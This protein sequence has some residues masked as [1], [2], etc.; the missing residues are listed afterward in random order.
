MKFLHSIKC[1]RLIP[2]VAVFLFTCLFGFGTPAGAV[3]YTDLIWNASVTNNVSPYFLASRIRQEV[4]VGSGKSNA[5]TGTVPG[6]TGIYNFYNIGATSGGNP[7][8]NGLAWAKGGTTYGR[9]WTDPQ[10]SISGGANF[11]A[12]SYIKV[13]QDS[14]YLQKFNVAPSNPSALYTHQYMTNLSAP[15]SEAST[16]FNA[17]NGAGAL[18]S[19]LVFYIPVYDA[20]P[21]LAG[22]PYTVAIGGLKVRSAATTSAGI[23]TSLSLGSNVQVRKWNYA[24]NVNGYNWAQVTLGNGITGYVAQGDSSSSWLNPLSGSAGTFSD[25]PVSY[26]PYLQALQAKYPQ[27]VFRPLNTGLNWST[28]VSNELGA[29]SAV[30]APTTGW[31][32]ASASP[33]IAQPLAWV[34]S[35]TWYQASRAAVEY[36]LDPR[37]GL[38]PVGV[39][40]FELLSFDATHQNAIGLA[41]LLSGTFMAGSTPVTYIDT[42]GK[43]QTLTGPATYNIIFDANGGTGAPNAQTKAQGIALKLSTDVPKRAGYI[44]LGWSTSKTATTGAWQPGATYTANA[45]ATL[46]AVWQNPQVI[47][48][49]GADRY[50]TAVAIAKKGWPSGAST[51]LLASGANYPDALAATPLAAIKDAP[52]LLT[53][54]SSTPS[55]TMDQIRALKPTDIILLGGTGVISSAQA[56]NLKNAGYNV[57][58]YG[59]ANRYETAQLIGDAVQAAGGS[60]TAILVTG[61]NYPDALSMGTIAGMNKM[62]IV[63]ST[64]SGLPPETT[65]FIAKNKITRIVSV[66]YTASNASIKSATQR[67][68]GAANVTY[69]TGADRYATS[70][71]V[72]NRYKSGFGNGIAVATGTNFP[73]ALTGAV[74]AAKMQCPV[75]LIDPTNGATPGVKSYVK[76]LSS[77]DIYV[78]GGAGVLKDAVIQGLYK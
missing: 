19:N 70:L 45:A 73:D 59:G 27:W 53:T 34:E 12:E 39:F 40:Q 46:Y 78:F 32:S 26:R 10:K 5:V 65:S 54:A 50:E 48:L 67:A 75:L 44:F 56:A 64:V 72:A 35:G 4:C 8:L 29:K 11:L 76:N 36:Y 7:V 43:L 38:S 13:G 71:A 69:I 2:V 23:I 25:F 62:P 20:M 30:P 14:K 68:V 9:P 63:F 16:T 33:M 21:T 57:T 42:S 17:Y 22:T 49:G 28:V 61:V 37:N 52:I 24:T 66:G 58:R 55:V 15:L 1:Y 6:Y 74:L 41:A 18:S 47:R 31:V 77:P 51:V 3:T 60:K